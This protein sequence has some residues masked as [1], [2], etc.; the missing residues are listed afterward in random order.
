MTTIVETLYQPE[1]LPLQPCPAAPATHL[2]G[3]VCQVEGCGGELRKAYHKRCA[4]AIIGIKRRRL[5][6]GPCARP[7]GA[8]GTR[9]NLA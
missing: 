9:V 6:L 1:P 7:P 3:L 2:K 4:V 5:S 8:P